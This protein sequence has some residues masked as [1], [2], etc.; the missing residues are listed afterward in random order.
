MTAQKPYFHDAVIIAKTG[1][2]LYVVDQNGNKLSDGYHYIKW[3][4]HEDDWWGKTG[5]SEYT[6]S[7]DTDQIDPWEARF[8][9]QIT[10][11][12]IIDKA[13]DE[14]IATLA[15]YIKAYDDVP[16]SDRVDFGA[17]EL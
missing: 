13:A 1:A 10:L 3:G 15:A 12:D 2:M 6:F 9:R 11:E 17:I 14:R 5:A 7:V 4:G 16:S 8:N